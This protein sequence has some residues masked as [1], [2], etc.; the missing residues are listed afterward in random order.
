MV[1]D[2]E[3][4]KML[5]ELI[6]EQRAIKDSL[7]RIDA[8]TRRASQKSDESRAV[9]HRRVDELVERVGDVEG[10]ITV[11]ASQVT[12][13]KAVTDDVKRWRHMGMGALAVVGIGGAAIG[14]T[15]AEA[16]RK[17]LLAVI[18]RL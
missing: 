6:A 7:N 3:L 10:E 14:V 2:A 16:A 5:G 18:G 9:M 13:A 17:L 1:A 8:E 12:D 11:M 15:F 4:Y